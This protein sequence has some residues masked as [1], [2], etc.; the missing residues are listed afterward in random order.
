VCSA[1]Y[2]LED[3]ERM[4][5]ATNYFEWQRK[6]V[7]REL[8]NRVIEVGCGIGNFTRML[9]DRELVIALD[10]EPECIERL[11]A[12]FAGSANLK[13]LV[14]DANHESISDLTEFAPDSCVLLNVLEHLAHD[15]DV[16]QRLA[17]VLVPGGAIVIL[18]PACP[19]LYG[20]IDRNLGHHRRYTRQSI[21]TL[22]QTACLEIRKIHYVN[23]TGLFGWWL[24]ARVMPRETQSARQISVFDRFVVPISSRLEAIMPP[25]IGQSLFAVLRKPRLRFLGEP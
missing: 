15:A 11:K 2:T 8:G 1:T 7:V 16:L 25:P 24:N 20:P 12:R 18:V 3:Q 10:S 21:F 14:G 5:S 4:T 19:A 9:L 6:L 23:F 22:A 17:S 13:T